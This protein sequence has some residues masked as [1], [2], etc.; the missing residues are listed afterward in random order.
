MK[1]IFVL[2]V[3][4]AFTLGICGL[5]NAQCPGGNCNQ[6]TTPTYRYGGNYY[7]GWGYSPFFP[8]LRFYPIS[9][10]FGWNQSVV[11]KS[12]SPKPDEDN[13]EPTDLKIEEGAKEVISEDVVEVIEKIEQEPEPPKEQ[14]H[15]VLKRFP[16]NP[17]KNQLV[18][19]DRDG[20][21]LVRLKLYWKDPTKRGEVSVLIEDGDIEGIQTWRKEL[22][23]QIKTEWKGASQE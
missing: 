19:T 3:L 22:W 2:A 10:G 11:G 18:V 9:P 23:D 20:R 17:E 12:E 15:L 8:I 1:K 14:R 7:A 21:V 13:A 4:A 6:Q 5:V 16:D